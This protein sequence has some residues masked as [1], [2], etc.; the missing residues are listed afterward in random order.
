MTGTATAHNRSICRIARNRS[1]VRS[2]AIQRRVQSDRDLVQV[3]ERVAD[4]RRQ[5]I[6]VLAYEWRTT[7]GRAA[8]DQLRF[9]LP[10]RLVASCCSRIRRFDTCYQGDHRGLEAAEPGADRVIDGLEILAE[11]LRRLGSMDAWKR[12]QR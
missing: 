1:R 6:E 12:R 5:R 8:R 9:E 3:L 11:R 4:A 10:N 7:S 2:R